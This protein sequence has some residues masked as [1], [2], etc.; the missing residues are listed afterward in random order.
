MGA[1]FNVEM[2]KT[3]TGPR[4]YV[5]MIGEKWLSDVI[6]TT[7]KSKAD[8]SKVKKG[9]SGDFQIE[10]LSQAVNSHEN[11]EII[12]GAWQ[13][14][15]GERKSTIVFCVDLAHVF[16]L[17]T[18]FRK[19]GV[20]ARVI[21]GNTPKQ[22]RSERLDAFKSQEFPVLLNCGI[23]TE[24]TDIPNIDCVL[25]AR[26]TKSRNLLVQMIGRGMRLHPG[27]TNCHVID[28]VASLDTGVVTTPTL[29]GL[30]PAELVKE[31]CVEDLKS[32]RE[33]KE[34]ESLRQDQ[35]A[36]L[37]ATLGQDSS[38]AVHN[39]TFNHFSI[40]DLINDTSGERHI[41]SIS[42]LSWVL[43]GQNRYVLANRDGSYVTIDG[44]SSSD[45]P[46]R[47]V[48]V[49]TA[50]STSFLPESAARI[51]TPPGARHRVTYTQ[52]LPEDLLLKG[53]SP[54]MRSR[55]IAQTVSFSDAVHAADT[56][57][58]RKF[59]WNLISYSQPWRK[60]PATE[61]QLTFLNKIRDR[62]DQLTAETLTKGK[63]SDMITKM[64]FGAKGQFDR[65]EADKRRNV[66]IREK[67]GQMA[68]VRQREQVKVGPLV[69]WYG[70]G[71]T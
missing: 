15:A 31:A 11:N 17:A 27:K 54:Y 22:V 23:F 47:G 50:L 38:P 4:D 6:F 3:L 14:Q 12:V 40:Y 39:V 63:A 24:G 26:P 70:D 57:A 35:G 66:R 10:G 25:L 45:A 56:F 9:I 58:T 29:F 60:K 21:T 5:D 46:S 65:L 18:V 68:A 7:V 69:N 2:I 49:R 13:D 62:G 41:R 20:D 43:V 44:A 48:R 53:K 42:H 33:R 28:I 34:V 8:L 1:I 36:E 37:P 59:A 71:M 19:Y 51:P 52:K 61:G 16:D 64:K 67:A 30:D 55:E 32:M